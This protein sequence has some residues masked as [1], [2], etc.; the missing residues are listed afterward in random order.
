MSAR[1]FLP[2]LLGMIALAASVEGRP[3]GCH[4]D[5]VLQRLVFRAPIAVTY[6]PPSTRRSQRLFWKFMDEAP[7]AHCEVYDAPQSQPR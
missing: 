4:R 5:T 2:A 1:F 6:S 7:D 3:G